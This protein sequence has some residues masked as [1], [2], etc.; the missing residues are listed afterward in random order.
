VQG[1]ARRARRPREKIHRPQTRR[2]RE[3]NEDSVEKMQAIR[4][5]LRKA[6]ELL[7]FVT[8]REQRKCSLAVRARQRARARCCETAAAAPPRSRAPRALPAARRGGCLLAGP[9]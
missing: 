6:Y 5:N 2:R 1:L 3:N 7:E 4:R 9:A 8:R